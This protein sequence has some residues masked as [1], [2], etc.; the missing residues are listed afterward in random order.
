MRRL[1]A[2]VAAT[3]LVAACTSKTN[4]H[5]EEDAARSTTTEATTA[6]TDPADAVVYPGDEWERADAVEM[7]F[8][9]AALDAVAATAEELDSTCFLVARQ[10]RIVG[11]WYWEGDDA[12]SAHEVFSVTK[13]FT[14]TLVGMAQADGDLAISDSASE[15]VEEWAGTDAEAVTIRN[16]LSNDS[17]REWSFG[18]DYSE[19]PAAADRTRFAVD[20]G[21]Q[22][23]PGEAWSYNNAA[24]QTLDRVLSVATGEVTADYA[25]ERL[26]GPLGM[27]DTEMTAD[28]SGNSTNAFFGLQSTCEDLA[29]FGYLFLR[30]GAWDG[31][32]I[33]PA[34]WVE[35]AT[36]APSQEHNAAY[37][38]LWW[39]NTEGRILSPLQAVTPTEEPE[40]VIGQIAPG[41]PTDMYTA[42]GL[43]GQI[44]MVDPGSETVVVRL[45][46][47]PAGAPTE[48]FR[49]QEAA[50][51]LTEALVE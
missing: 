19:L 5:P 10:G 50:R 2:L 27:D 36:G 44:V 37:G 46:A 51:V 49:A 23:P 42:Q 48:G 26:F 3:V 17:G 24:I 25:A 13:S 28:P 1:A 40:E 4:D 47:G 32:Q 18:L 22:Y 15:Y 12:T 45:G 31:E 34:E 29:R 8:D 11:E 9:Q 16:L 38:Y 33:V 30:E 7:G 14:S 39:L 41:A 43:G 6:A 35:E 20:L 21:Q